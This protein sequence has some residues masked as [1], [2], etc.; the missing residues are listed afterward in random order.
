V[1]TIERVGPTS[2]MS[3][4]KTTNASAVQTTPSPTTDQVASADGHCCGACASPNGR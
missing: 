4:K 1:M 2:A 3:A